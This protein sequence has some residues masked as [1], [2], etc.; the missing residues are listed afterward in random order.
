MKVLVVFAHPEERSFN[1]SLLD[2]Y[3]KH[4]ESQGNEV[5]VS[6]LYKQNFKAVVDRD[7]FLNLD[8]DARL[9]VASASYGAFAAKQLTP[10]VVDEMDKLVWADTIVFHFPIWWFGMPAILKGWVDRV[11]ACGFAYGTGEYTATRFGD[12]YGEGIFAGKKAFVVTTCGGS[13][14]Q[15]SDRGINGPIDHVLFTINHGL[16]FYTGCEVLPAIVIHRTDGRKEE[17]FKEA[18]DLVNERFDK[19][20]SVEPINYRKQNFGDYEIPSLRLKEGLEL[21]NE[22]GYDI[23]IAKK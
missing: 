14:E 3:V 21:P 7:D 23:H 2:S 22:S 15:Y 17:G 6:D 16:L 20:D 8:K 9:Q 1:K 4:L 19:F 10:D 13:V 5:K 18:V 11:F 12:R